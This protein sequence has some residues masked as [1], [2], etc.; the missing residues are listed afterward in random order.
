MRT[1][2]LIPLFLLAA[3]GGNDSSAPAQAGTS[4]TAPQAAMEPAPAEPAPA[5]FKAVKLRNPLPEGIEFPFAYHRLND[6]LKKDQGTE[7]RRVFVEILGTAPQQAQAA[8][9]QALKGKGFAEPTSQQV[10]GVTEFTYTRADGT[11]VIV[12]LNDRL[13]KK[14]APDATGT[15]HLTWRSA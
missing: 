14:K 6:N 7:D 5:A 15:I 8:L 3:C 13:K 10:K 1:F 11:Q 4:E 12:K 2:L 9:D